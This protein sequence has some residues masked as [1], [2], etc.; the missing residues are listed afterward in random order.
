MYSAIAVRNS[1]FRQL[2]CSISAPPALT[3]EVV[4]RHRADAHWLVVGEDW[5]VVARCSLWWR[6]VPP[7]PGERLGV[8]GHYHAA[9]NEAAAEILATACRQLALS[10]CTAAVGPMDGNVWRAYRLVTD[11]GTEPPFFLEPQ[12]PPEWPAQFTAAG[13][14]P[15]ADYYSSRIDLNAEPGPQ[16]STRAERIHDLGIRIRPLDLDHF[17]SELAR[18][19]RVALTGFR[20]SFLFTPISE[21]EFLEQYRPWQTTLRPEFVLIAQAG[22]EVAGFVFAVPDLLELR[23]TGSV[24]TLVARTLCVLPEFAGIGLGS[25]LMERVY[26]SARRLGYRYAIHALMHEKN[27]SRRIR[28]DRAATLRRYTLFGRALR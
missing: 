26:Q 3:P 6:E 1:A 7:L 9:D 22:E 27:L 21:T 13:F 17:P 18:L 19:F 25:V 20:D 23:R 10:G 28:A 4:A 8:I 15:L 12:N 11:P 14:S 2:F 5:Q 16:H 24:Q